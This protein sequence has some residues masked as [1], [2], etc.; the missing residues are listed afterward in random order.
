MNIQLAVSLLFFIVAL[1][2]ARYKSKKKAYLVLNASLVVI[3]L[4]VTIT[5]LSANFFTGHGVDEAVIYTIVYGLGDAG[6]GD[7]I[8]LIAVTTL[9]VIATFAIGYFYY[10]FIKGYKHPSPSKIKGFIHNTFFILAFLSHPLFYNLYQIYSYRSIKHSNDFYQ[11]YKK[12]KI[13]QIEG[14]KMNLVYIVAESFE[15][16]YFDEKLFPNLVTHLKKIKN[17]ST[18]FTDVK[19]VIATGWT[20]GGLTATQCA[21]PLF[22]PSDGNSMG[23]SDK[24]LPGAV[25]LGDVLHKAG[26]HQVYIQGAST[27]FSGKDK[28]FKTHK[29]DEIYGRDELQGRLKDKNYLN[30]WGLYDD[31]TF[32]IA[33]KKY[34]DLSKSGKPF[35]LVIMT[36]D[37]HHP[38]GHISKTCKE[39]G[40]KY[41][42]GDNPILNAVKCSDYLI[43]K[44]IDKIKHSKYAKDTIIVMTSDHLAME[45]TATSILKKGKRRDFVMLIDPKDKG[46]HLIIN[47]PALMFD[48]ASTILNKL[49]IKTD[50]G[51]GRDIL[52]EDSLAVK[53]KDI[54]KKLYSWR[55][56]ILKFWK[57]PKLSSSIDINVSDNSALIS[58]DRYKLP[59]YLEIE[60][61]KTI[62][63]HF[64]LN[65][66]DKTHHISYQLSKLPKYKRFIWIDSCEKINFVYGTKFNKE[67]CVAKGTLSKGVNIIALDND[68]NISTTIDNRDLIGAGKY[69]DISLKMKKLVD[70]KFIEPVFSFLVDAKKVY[71]SS[72]SDGIDFKKDGYPDFIRKVWGV[73]GKE[74]WGRWSD[75][76]LAPSVKF[77][78]KKPLPKDFMLELKVGAFGKNIGKDTLIKVGNITKRL[79]ISSYNPRVYKI[80][81]DG[82]NSDM[83]EFIAP[84]PQ[85]PSKNG[86]KLGIS[87]ESLKILK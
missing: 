27:K 33:Y 73:S 64:D 69:D 68:N 54:D 41:G 49:G 18:E 57:F 30:A 11:Y 16:T 63:P 42:N 59:L 13:S 71:H 5:Y 40:I 75:A 7:Y 56:D 3:Y 6:F 34:E 74:S 86:R 83:I 47:K 70:I 72:L 9:G 65:I 45:N 67:I 61:D 82:V 80:K 51:L 38:D 58:S 19:Q 12:P 31:T 1:T 15:R 37:T 10:R 35:S 85:S 29:Y 79:K 25:C 23:G 28:F 46:R 22:T 8:V 44:L 66:F 50:L 48:Q 77:Q 2:S 55:E 17:H 81:F 4:L 52:H 32:D 53:F 39:A 78:F 36:L 21:I 14:K 43:S 60:A 24:Y 20:I 76:N 84:S 87:F 62:E 26:Y